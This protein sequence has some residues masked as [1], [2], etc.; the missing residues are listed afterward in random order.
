VVRASHPAPK[1]RPGTT[2]APARELP[3]DAAAWHRAVEAMG[4]SPQQARIVELLLRGMRD[5]QIAAELGLGV[6]TIR[7]YLARV[8]QRVGVCDRV[9]L[10]LRVVAVS[11]EP[12]PTGRHRE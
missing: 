7:T 1:E 2:P 4:L 12:A 10:I 6:P 3:I 5:K 9:E 8:F 11:R